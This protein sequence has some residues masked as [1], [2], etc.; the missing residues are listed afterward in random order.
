MV[1]V[2]PTDSESEPDRET[3]SDGGERRALPDLTDGAPL[4]PDLS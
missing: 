4:V 2:M 3:V 1:P